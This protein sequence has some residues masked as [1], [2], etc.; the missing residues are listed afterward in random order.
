[1]ALVSPGSGAVAAS[2]IS[3]ATRLLQNEATFC[4]EWLMPVAWPTR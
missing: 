4:V 3:F 1:M 2:R